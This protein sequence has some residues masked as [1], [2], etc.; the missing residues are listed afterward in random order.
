VEEK[1]E[2][3]EDK[4]KAYKLLVGLPERNRLPRKIKSRCVDNIKMHLGEIECVGIG[5]I[6]LAR[7]WDQ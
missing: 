3:K 7:N 2:V 1:E 5:W 4:K 6:G